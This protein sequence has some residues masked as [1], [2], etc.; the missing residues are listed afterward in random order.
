[1]L[2]Q[3]PGRVPAQACGALQGRPLP[4]DR[5]LEGLL[6]QLAQAQTAKAAGL[7]AAIHLQAAQQ[8]QELLGQ[9]LRV[10]GV[11]EMLGDA[12]QV[13]QR[14]FALAEIGCALA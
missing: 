7:A 3:P 6:V 11:P 5:D 14:G 4:L 2:Q 12:A 1:M 13:Q 10:A 8:A 9:G